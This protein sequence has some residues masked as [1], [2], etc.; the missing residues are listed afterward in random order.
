MTRQPSGRQPI[1]PRRARRAAARAAANQEKRGLRADRRG[2][3]VPPTVAGFEAVLR[4]RG[5]DGLAEALIARHNQRMQRMLDVGEMMQQVVLPLLASQL[6]LNLIVELLGASPWR[7]P[8][9]SG[10]GWP[11]HLGWGLDST[12]GAARFMLSI[13]PIGAAILA[14][15]QMERWSAN[16]EF[17]S[18]IEQAPGEDTTTWFNRLWSAPGMWPP[19]TTEPPPVGDIYA[20]LS[21]LLHARGPLMPL[22]WLDTVDITDDPSRE[23]VEQLDII[24]DA[25]IVSLNQVRRCLAT[26]LEDNGH[27]ELAAYVYSVPLVAPAK[28]RLPNLAAFLWPMTPLLFQNAGAEA[29]LGGAATGMREVI[30]ARCEDREPD[31]PEQTWPVLCFGSH[32]FRALMTARNAYRAEEAILGDRFGE[33]PIEELTTEAVLAGEM[34]ALLALWLRHDP[35]RGSAANAFVVCAS[36]LRSAEWL[37]LE[38]DPRAMGCLRCVIEQLARARTWRTKPHRALK[39]EANPNSTPRD[40]MEGAVET[41]EPTQ[42]RPRRVRAWSDDSE[43]Q[44]GPPSSRR[45][46]GKRGHR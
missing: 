28:S 32:R 5:F 39:I 38:D 12:V 7:Q 11:A 24:G 43:L 23:H 17:N 21:E 22:V 26:A 19:P 44:P 30:L 1:Q 33:S 18:G 36:A 29:Q 16:L 40:W 27:D 46:A 8:F 4:D 37:W 10:E 42:P 14:R 45:N 13:Q 3:A 2:R 20:D 6:P 41:L 31:Q 35:G 9:Q 34:A 25:V 15:T